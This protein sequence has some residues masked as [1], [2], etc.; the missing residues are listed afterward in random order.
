ME[1]DHQPRHYRLTVKLAGREYSLELGTM[2]FAE[3]CTLATDTVNRHGHR[4]QNCRLDVLVSDN[5][6]GAPEPMTWAIRG[7][8]W[9]LAAE[10]GEQ[11]KAPRQYRWG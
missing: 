1:V 6:P 9:Y 3:A 10:D 5:R 4:P 7:W 11:T 2:T 8:P